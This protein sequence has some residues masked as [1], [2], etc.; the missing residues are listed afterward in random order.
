MRSSKPKLSE[1]AIERAVVKYAKLL[2]W[3]FVRKVR[4]IGRR[5]CPDRLF[6]KAGRYIW[7]EFK[8]PGEPLRPDQV[9]EI[10]RLRKHGAEVHV[11]DDIE[12]GRAVFA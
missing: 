5:A 1:A 7:I 11:I 3:K 9:R 6:L 10:K 8:A 4:W 12:M 2:G